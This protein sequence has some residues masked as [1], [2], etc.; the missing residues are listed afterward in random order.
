MRAQVPPEARVVGSPVTA[1]KGG[2]EPPG[3][4]AT[5]EPSLQPS[6]ESSYVPLFSKHGSD[7]I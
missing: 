5:A 4:G 6:M 1:V 7:G 2:C 3:V